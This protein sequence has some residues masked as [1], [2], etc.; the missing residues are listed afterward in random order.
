MNRFGDAVADGWQAWVFASS[1]RLPSFPR[2]PLFFSWPFVLGPGGWGGREEQS[3]TELGRRPQRVCRLAV[4]K[5][6][7]A[8]VST[9]EDVE[10][11]VGAPVNQTE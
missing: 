2:P 8:I 10:V 7:A 1:E 9:G 11:E 3:A 6:S 4:G 5:P